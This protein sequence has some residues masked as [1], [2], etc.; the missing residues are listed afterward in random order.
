M[1]V[2][3]VDARHSYRRKGARFVTRIIETP[4]GFDTIV[5]GQTF[6]TWRSRAEAKAGMQVE[7]QRATRITSG[8]AAYKA[9]VAVKPT[10]GDG[11]LR[12]TWAALSDIARWSWEREKRA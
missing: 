1:E 12:P 6:G 2:L 7:E 11:T 4:H 3:P 9:D 8:Q 10:Y 5:N